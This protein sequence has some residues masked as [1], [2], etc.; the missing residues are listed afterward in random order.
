MIAAGSGLL[1]TVLV[2]AVIVVL[3]LYIA[4]RI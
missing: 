3:V 1:V 4:R 2:I